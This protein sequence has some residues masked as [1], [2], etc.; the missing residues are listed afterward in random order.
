LPLD[1]SLGD[2]FPEGGDVSRALF[3]SGL[4]PMTP[5]G[6]PVIGPAH[7]DNLVLNTGH[8]TLGWT[9]AC[10]AGKVVADQITGHRT[11]IPVEG[12]SYTRYGRG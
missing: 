6:P 10:G 11:D 12:L 3:W 4:R 1:R 2:L 7:L 9:M 5:D 8:G